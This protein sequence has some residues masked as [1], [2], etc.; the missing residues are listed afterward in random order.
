MRP[1]Q[2][3]QRDAQVRHAS[4]RICS[5]SILLLRSLLKADSSGVSVGEGI[6]IPRDRASRH[7]RRDSRRHER[8]PCTHRQ[9]RTAVHGG[10]RFSHPDAAHRRSLH[11]KLRN[12]PRSA[13]PGRAP[14]GHQARYGARTQTGAEHRILDSTWH[15]PPPAV[16]HLATG[17][18]R[19]TITFVGRVYLHGAA[20]AVLDKDC[21][22]RPLF[23]HLAAQGHVIMDVAN[24][25]FPETDM[26]GMV[27]DARR[28]VV[29]LKMHAVEYGLDPGHVVLGGA[30][31]GGHIATLAAYT[32]GD[33]ELTP[34]DVRDADTSKVN[35]SQTPDAGMTKA[36]FRLVSP[37]CD[38]LAF[39]CVLADCNARARSWES[40]GT[41]N[42]L[43]EGLGKGRATTDHRS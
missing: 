21:A 27:A 35:C 38:Y 42:E 12:C 1:D 13:V 25:L 16:R 40:A 4:H 9:L 17:G 14:A 18:R 41:T 15:E 3:R 33:P 39:T 31:S 23:S 6:A 19:T 24:R 8:L 7:P 20:W 11:R 26:P 28:A 29:W 5:A 2:A 32:V 36:W 37:G 22:T 30:S 10:R 34:P 43:L